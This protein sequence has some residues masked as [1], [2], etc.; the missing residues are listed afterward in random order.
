MIRALVFGCS[1]LAASVYGADEELLVT[2]TTGPVQGHYNY[3]GVREWNGIPYAKPPVGD[4]RWE[5]PQTPNAWTDTYDA[6]FMAPG[7]MQECKL[8][9][10]NCPEYGIGEDC[11]YLSVWAPTEPSPDPEGYPVFYW[12]H[13]GAFEQGLGDCA[14]YNG[15]NFAMKDVITVVINYRLGAF[16]FL[17]SASMDGNYGL[18]D[19]R[20][21][22]EWVRDNI[23]GFGGNPNDVT[24]G[25]Q[26]AGGMSVGA[27]MTMPGSKGLFHKVVQESNPLGLPCHE[28]ESAQQN[29]DDVF[30]YMSC[31]ADDVTCAKARPAEDVLEAQN[32][33]PKLNFNN[34]FINFMPWSPLVEEDGELPQQP[35]F[36]LMNGEVA[37]VPLFTGSVYD[38]GQLFVQELFTSPMSESAYKGL[39][40][41]VFGAKNYPEIMHKYPL[42]VVEGST[43]GRD[44]LNV[45]ATDLLFYCPLRNV[46]RGYQAA[47]GM[48]AIP[49]YIYRFKHVV[50]FDCWGEDYEFCVGYCCHGSELPFVFNVFTDGVSVA[51]DPTADEEQLTVDLADAWSNFIANSDPNKGLYVP[52]NF[53]LYDGTT[54]QLLVLEEPGS[55]VQD[56]VRSEYCDMWDRMGF[57][58]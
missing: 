36:A 8:P 43:D 24:I 17:A 19:Q 7:C 51:Y 10:G 35:L 47:L 4:L 20:K 37:N 57:F 33:A 1:V 6:S 21:G 50:S 2:T 44:A 38:E 18:M 32:N 52:G 41:A 48:D 40:L 23:K 27:H 12:I 42:S 9:P 56:H 22:M 39:V 49:T 45:L 46:T 15:T 29:A 14:L 34:L 11:L 55:E 26:S 53:P 31:P 25:G 30:E 16:G 28:R 54:D 13:G 3:L 5:N 58:Y